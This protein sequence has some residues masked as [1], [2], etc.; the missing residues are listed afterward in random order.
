M[1][2]AIESASDNNNQIEE[3]EM[4]RAALSAWVD[5]TKELLKWIEQQGELLSETRNPKQMMALG[6]FKTHIIMGIKALKY[7]EN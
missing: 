3:D 5:Q 7:A 2:A 4:L 1:K 6:S